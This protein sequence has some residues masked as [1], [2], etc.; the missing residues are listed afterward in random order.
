MGPS[1]ITAPH[2]LEDIWGMAGR[3]LKDVSPLFRSDLTIVSTFVMVA[4]STTGEPPQ[5]MKLKL[6]NLID[7]IL[8]GIARFL[9]HGAHHQ[10]A[11]ADLAD[12]PFLT[13]GG[14]LG[15]CA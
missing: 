13:P 10:R 12:Q 2:L 11:F 4:T 8:K 9:C 3:S 1:L 6:Q 15:G 7:K 14:F 5:K